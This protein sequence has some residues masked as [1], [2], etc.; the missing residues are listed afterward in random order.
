M[1]NPPWYLRTNCLL[2][3]VST[4]KECLPNSKGKPQ[5][6]DIVFQKPSKPYNAI[7]NYPDLLSMKFGLAG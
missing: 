7:N 5:A 3:A 2:S 1:C 6:N 4:G